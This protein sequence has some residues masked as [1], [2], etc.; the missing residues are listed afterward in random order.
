MGGLEHEITMNQQK[1]SEL[2]NYAEVACL[3]VIGPHTLSDGVKG[4]SCE[5]RFNAQSCVLL[6]W[7]VS[8]NIEMLLKPLDG[9]FN[10]CPTLIPTPFENAAKACFVRS[11]RTNCIQELNNR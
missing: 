7:F 2:K 9:C 8:G 3:Q 6:S 5:G 11:S 1:S 10:V 4:C